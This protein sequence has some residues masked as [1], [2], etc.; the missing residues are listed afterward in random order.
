MIILEIL[1]LPFIIVF[2]LIGIAFK[3]AAF[4][5]QVVIGLI[6]GAISLMVTAF[7]FMTEFVYGVIALPFVLLASFLMWAWQKPTTVK[8]WKS[9]KRA[10][11]KF[12]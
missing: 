8:V 9:F 1:A 5:L 3:V 11:R 10:F 7:M 4:I 2:G 12:W 6:V